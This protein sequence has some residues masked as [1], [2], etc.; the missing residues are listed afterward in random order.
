MPRRTKSQQ[1]EQLTR[2][3]A[4]LELQN[5]WLSEELAT[6]NELIAVYEELLTQH[7]L[8]EQRTTQPLFVD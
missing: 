5:Y 1:I 3:V 2:D 6:S 7:K 4:Q 8:I